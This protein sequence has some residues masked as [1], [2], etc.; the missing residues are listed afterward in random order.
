MLALLVGTAVG[1]AAQSLD[2]LVSIDIGSGS[3]QTDIRS[4]TVEIFS[5]GRDIWIHSDAFRFAYR[6]MSEDFGIEATVAMQD[7]PDEYAKLGIMIRESSEPGSR[8]I[9]LVRTRD[10][11]LEFQT[12]RSTGANASTLD[13]NR[14]LTSLPVGIRLWRERDK[15]TAFY[16]PDGDVWTELGQADFAGADTLLVGF[17][18]TSGD[19]SAEGGGMLVQASVEPLACV[20]TAPE[21]DA[22][23]DQFVYT[24]SR[25]QIDL[26]V[27]TFSN[28]C[29][30]RVTYSIV[31]GPGTID[32]SLFTWLPETPVDED[33]TIAASNLAG[34]TEAIFHVTAL[35][36]DSAVSTLSV[37]GNQIVDDEDNPVVLR[38]VAIADLRWIDLFHGGRTP[39]SV[40]QHA[41]DLGSRVVRLTVLPEYWLEGPNAY[42]SEMID[43]IVRL[44][45]REDFYVIIDWHYVADGTE[46]DRPLFTEVDDETRSFWDVIS[47]TYA[48][49]PN[50]I[51]ELFNE[52]AQPDDWSTWRSTAQPWINLI[53]ENAGNLLLV[54]G[55]GYS[56]R[57]HYVLDDP[58]E[59]ENLAY[60]A[61]TYPDQ[62]GHTNP[63]PER[64]WEANWGK[65]ADTYPVVLTEWGY[66]N[67]EGPHWSGG[68][69]E[70]YGNPLQAY[71]ES[72]GVGWTAWV[73]DSVWGP[74]MFDG[75]W[76][77]LVGNDYM[78]QFTVDWLGFYTGESVPMLR[79][80]TPRLSFGVTA[81]GNEQVRS[82]SLWNAG[83]STLTLSLTIDHDQFVFDDVEPNVSYELEPGE[84]LTVTVRFL[85]QRGGQHEGSI[86]ISHN[87]VG[88]DRAIDLSGISRGGVTSN[89]SEILPVTFALTASYPNP[90]DEELNVEVTTSAPDRIEIELFDVLGAR[91]A[92]MPTAAISAGKTRIRV[93]TDHLPAGIYVVQIRAE[94]GGILNKLVTLVR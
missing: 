25:V 3:G 17:V 15:I 54:S 38:G 37:S 79:A 1:T 10:N 52:P 64:V 68:T 43:P 83:D 29:S 75:A 81:G 11:G 87:A 67:Y 57:I 27:L 71:V 76:N 45:M 88:T 12:R 80:S 8:F 66:E 14:G 50:V 32:D 65:V 49:N 74:R 62:A 60:V 28:A 31:G 6:K 51:F 24:G 78:G 56:S 61:H 9:D 47:K 23:P 35:E 73:F 63:N 16:R 48:G 5:T 58:F 34:S 22:P 40:T 41:V 90:F 93:Q 42:L 59:G 72:R 46:D 77:L 30:G 86:L 89:E 85:A 2:D 70:N 92:S 7:G 91:V 84:E 39:L 36:A 20:E 19:G 69:Q 53:R 21:F 55:L 13:T 18:A 26:S 33:I 44:A 4:D 94:S 82:L